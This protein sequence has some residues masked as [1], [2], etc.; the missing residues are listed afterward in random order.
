[1]S[2]TSRRE[3]EKQARIEAIKASAWKI[4][5]KDG[6]DQAK[7]ADIARDCR[8]GLSTIYYYFKDKRQIV[9][10]LMLDFKR[11]VNVRQLL[12]SKPSYRTFFISYI[13]LHLQNIEAFRFFVLADSYYNY[14]NQY[15]LSDP[16]LKEYDRITREDGNYLLDAVA[17]EL[18]PA[19]RARLQVIISMIL[20]F[21]RRYILLPEKSWPR[22]E[23][24]RLEMMHNLRELTVC[25]LREIGIDPEKEIIFP[26]T[27]AG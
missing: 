15:D 17:S 14:H 22:N 21:L 20:G 6:F 11:S 13:E 23:E 12:D 8:L 16:V 18:D 25:L 1:M 24:E 10:S 7:I 2:V 9:Y 26:G 19:G 3:E 5:L 27:D 4:F